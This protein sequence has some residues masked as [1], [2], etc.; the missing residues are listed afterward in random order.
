MQR[1]LFA[2][3]GGTSH[4]KSGTS[5][6]HPFRCQSLATA[7]F[8]SGYRKYRKRQLRLRRCLLLFQPRR[9]SHPIYLNR[10]IISPKRYLPYELNK[11]LE[12]ISPP[13]NSSYSYF[14]PSFRSVR[15]QTSLSI[16]LFQHPLALSIF[17]TKE[18]GTRTERKEVGFR[19]LN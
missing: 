13:P 8:K 2:R 16:R 1:L 12:F 10:R 17:A 3:P 6:T 9:N 19:K 7:A 11:S 5:P 18:F 4:P 15:S 14:L